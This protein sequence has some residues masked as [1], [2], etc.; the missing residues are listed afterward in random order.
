LCKGAKNVGESIDEIS[1]AHNVPRGAG[2]MA[3]AENWHVVRITYV[4]ACVLAGYLHSFAH[5]VEI[6]NIRE[7]FFRHGAY[8]SLIVA[9]LVLDVNEASGTKARQFALSR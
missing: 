7:L 3:I 2:H 5:P 8:Q 1:G 4:L 6:T 9:L